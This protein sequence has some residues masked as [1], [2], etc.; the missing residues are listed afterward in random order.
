MVDYA[1]YDLFDAPKYN[2]DVEEYDEIAF[3]PDHLKDNDNGPYVIDVVGNGVHFMQL[4]KAR[5]ELSL[6]YR[7]LDVAQKT[8]ANLGDKHDASV[9]PFIA[10]SLFHNVRFKVANIEIPELTQN[11]FAYKAYLEEVLGNTKENVDV[12]FRKQLGNLDMPGLYENTEYWKEFNSYTSTNGVSLIPKIFENV[13]IGTDTVTKFD[14]YKVRLSG[15]WQRKDTFKDNNPLFVSSPLHIDFL[16]QP[17]C[18]PPN[19][20]MSFIFEKNITEFFALSQMGAAGMPNLTIDKMRIVTPIVKLH[21]DLASKLLTRWNNEPISY[22]YQYVVPRTYHLPKGSLFWEDREICQGVLPKA[23]YFVFVKTENYNGKLD[24]TPYKFENLALTR[25]ELTKNA[26][27]MNSFTLDA[28]FDTTD[29]LQSYN[30]FLKHAKKER[31]DCLINHKYFK[32]DYTIIPFDLTPD[33]NNNYNLYEPTFATLG[34]NV[35][36]PVLTHNYVA[37][38]FFVYNK[39][40]ELDKHLRVTIKDI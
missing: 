7:V 27:V 3:Y 36:F 16:N 1:Q 8:Y 34:V 14:P 33:F 15:V 38:A 20:S 31:E 29:A 39:C 10:T 30:H 5:L 26:Q 25:F 35:K 18:F 32:T 19:F 22:S 4:N 6:K 40:M 11:C 37:I 2:D 28:D 12:Y 21:P 24:M 23:I 9:V 17:K 13:T